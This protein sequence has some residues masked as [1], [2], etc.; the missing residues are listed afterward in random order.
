MIEELE[1]KDDFKL[2]KM[3]ENRRESLKK[4]AHLFGT[5]ETIK[6]VGISLHYVDEETGTLQTIQMTSVD[7][8][9]YKE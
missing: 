5:G 8:D 3:I 6:F 1:F 2:K 4:T 9:K 7:L